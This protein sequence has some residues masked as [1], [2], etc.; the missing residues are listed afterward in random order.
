MSSIV[1][2][3]ETRKS[4]V[5]T[6][7]RYISFSSSVHIFNVKQTFFDHTL[8]NALIARFSHLTIFVSD[9]IA[10][11]NSSFILE[12]EK[13][14]LEILHTYSELRLLGR[15]SN[16]SDDQQFYSK[17]REL[18]AELLEARNK[19]HFQYFVEL[20]LKEENEFC[21]NTVEQFVEITDFVTAFAKKI[22][23]KVQNNL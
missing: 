2:L 4:V 16:C 17:Y 1:K 7:E 13:A 6:I 15:V 22:I 9:V 18:N 10:K 19:E 3:N 8:L 11:A 21:H 14:L 5:S 23:K 12:Q 20:V